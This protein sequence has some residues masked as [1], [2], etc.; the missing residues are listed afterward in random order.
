MIASGSA[1]RPLMKLCATE[2]GAVGHLGPVGASGMVLTRNPAGL[3]IFGTNQ[4]TN[5]CHLF[6]FA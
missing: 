6:F 4:P 1:W 2:L 5:Q 3:G